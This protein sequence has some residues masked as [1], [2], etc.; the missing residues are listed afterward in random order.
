MLVRC[1]KVSLIAFNN[2]VMFDKYFYSQI[3]AL[4]KSCYYHI[5]DICCLPPYLDFKTVSTIATTLVHSKLHYRNLLS[6]VSDKTR[7]SAIA[8]RPCCKMHYSFGQKWKTGTG[9][10]YFTDI[11][12]LSSTTV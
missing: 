5:R 9:K 8:K 12:C 7:C 11:I 6:T 4:S 3:S 1:T 10:Q 2:H